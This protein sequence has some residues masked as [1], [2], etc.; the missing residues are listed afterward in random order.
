[1]TERLRP[2]YAPPGAERPGDYP[3]TRG[4]SA[5]PKPWIM[6]QYAGFGTARESNA[7]F[8]K[9]LAAGQTGF[10]VALD[11]PTQLGLDSDDPRAAGEVG[12]VGVA[13]DSLADVEALIDLL[14]APYLYRLLIDGQP[15]DAKKLLL[16]R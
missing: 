7:R 6:G 2:D 5:E 14:S 15:I 9:L 8:R 11:L 10:S 16:N 12:R 3:Y 1:V 4:I 13:I